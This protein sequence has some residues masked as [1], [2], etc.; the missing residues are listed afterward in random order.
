MSLTDDE[1]RAA[2]KATFFSHDCW[3]DLDGSS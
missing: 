3:T 1:K 2:L